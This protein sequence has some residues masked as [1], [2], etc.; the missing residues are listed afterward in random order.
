MSALASKLAA[1][2]A[3]RFRALSRKN[4][5]LL[6][7]VAVPL[8]AIPLLFMTAPEPNVVDAEESSW[9]VTT[10]N[11]EPEALSPQATLF[12]RVETPRTALLT[13]AVNAQV[14]DVHVREGD[15]VQRNDLLIKLD[16]EDAQ[17]I[18]QQREADVAEAEAN[19]AS[20]KLQHA[21]NVA[22][23]KHE[24][25]LYELSEKKLAWNR[26][27]RVNKAISEEMMNN[28][29]R[30]SH[31]Q[32][33][34]LQAKEGLVAN[35]ENVL[36]QAEARVSRA[37][38]NLEEAR[39]QLARTEIRAPFAGR[40][41]R[42]DLAPGERVTV[43]M[44]LAELYDT[45]SLEIRAQIP[46]KVLAK[47]GD[48]VHDLAHRPLTADVA[49]DDTSLAA[50]LT[51]LS[52]MVKQ[53]NSGVDGF[54]RVA[55]PDDRLPLGRVVNLT[56]RLPVE[57]DV[58]KVPIQSIYGEDHV[59]V[60]ENEHLVSVTINRL[61]E[62]TDESGHYYIL[63][64]APELTAGMPIVTTQLSNAI[65]GMKVTINNGDAIIAGGSGPRAGEAG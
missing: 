34:S 1:P 58:V 63:I 17:L 13:S 48:S 62:L 19:L 14:V 59:F 50:H 33:I 16:G 60:V 21:D 5:I 2:I 57:E 39:V 53:G 44:S 56:L 9:S 54:F 22:I 28:V 25:A 3:N 41:T 32:A 23:L 11:A 36:H 24:R 65:S 64:R 20:L 15:R 8:L 43:G 35:F 47:L 55:D 51:R 6:T 10:L 61:G 27:L 31:Q 37:N 46:S 45:D 4:R 49:L 38:A 42:V 12:G 40:I 52:G 18:V 29:T 26:E 7:V 30:E